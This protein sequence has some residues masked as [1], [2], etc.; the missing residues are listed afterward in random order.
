M[1]IIEA[2][3]N[4]RR[5][6]SS[7][8]SIVTLLQLYLIDNP[9]SD[10]Y[11]KPISLIPLIANN[12]AY[13]EIS[14]NNFNASQG[15]E[16]EEIVLS[17]CSYYQSPYLLGTTDYSSIE[18]A[19]SLVQGGYLYGIAVPANIDTGIPLS[20][21]IA[22]GLDAANRI[23]N[24]AWTLANLKV[25]SNLTFTKLIPD[26]NYN[27]YITCGNL[28]P[29]YPQLN[30]LVTMI[31]WKTDLAPAPQLLKISKSTLIMFNLLILIIY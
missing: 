28:L 12:L 3:N 17:E 8:D 14:L 16:G 13:L 10:D 1:Q 21:Q 15:V 22:K 4:N 9:N 25:D 6:S 20:Y 29:G 19:A 23:T 24:S 2:N 26:S 5:L 30:S 7:S 31:Q 27:L 18:L 11:P